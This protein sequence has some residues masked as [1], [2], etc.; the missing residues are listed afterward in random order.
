MFKLESKK[1]KR[2]FNI[3]E[4]MLYASQVINTESGM[5]FIPDG[6]A[7]ATFAVKFCDGDEFKSKNLR[8]R[9][10]LKRTAAFIFALTGNEQH[11]SQSITALQRTA[12]TIEKQNAISQSEPKAFDYVLLE[13]VGI[14]NSQSSFTVERGGRRFLFKFRP[15]FY[16]DSLF[17]GCCSLAAKTNAIAHG[18]RRNQILYRQRAQK[19][20][21][22][23]PTPVMEGAAVQACLSLRMLFLNNLA[24]NFPAL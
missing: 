15:A 20:K 9:K 22:L 8:L 19:G 6:A 21:I 10:R 24:G 3:N 16:I 7:A 2:E 12:A 14:V 5:T 17:F 1:L 13:N 18:Q 11:H 4:G 23:C